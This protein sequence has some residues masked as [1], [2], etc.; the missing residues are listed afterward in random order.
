MVWQGLYWN[1]GLYFCLKLN[2]Y[3]STSQVASSLEFQQRFLSDLNYITWVFV[4]IIIVKQFLY[5]LLWTKQTTKSRF[6]PLSLF[7]SFSPFFSD[8][9]DKKCLWHEW[10]KKTFFVICFQKEI[11][12]VKGSFVWHVDII[13]KWKEEDR[14]KPTE[15]NLLW[16]NNY[17]YIISRMETYYRPKCYLYNVILN[18]VHLPWEAF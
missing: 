3:F 18:S 2:K 15:I 7:F 9:H 4:L 1:I 17:L 12:N 6:I 10:I 5:L 13:D 8:N 11:C 16:I 14:R